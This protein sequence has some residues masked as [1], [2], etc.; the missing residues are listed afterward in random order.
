MTVPMK[1]PEPAASPAMQRILAALQRKPALSIADLAVEAF[2]GVSTLACGG[3]IGA[4]RKRRLIHVSGWRKVHGRFATPLYSLG[5]HDDVPRPRIDES[6]RAAPGMQIIVQ[7]LERY[8]RLDY[9]EIA[10]Y[11]GL[12]PHTVKNSGFLAALIAQ[13]RIH[14]GD[15]RRSAHGP[16]SPLYRLGAGEAAPKP[17]ALS[18]A[19][20][21]RRQRA[22]SKIAAQG[23]GLSSQIARLAAA[24]ENGAPHN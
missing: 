15:W 2:V 9:R 17:A 22:R 8:G 11:S 24:L 5:Q 10:R 6:N 4:L 23:A 21:C 19:Q 18:G 12:S 14:I 7:T 13:G 1:T 16:L 20:K 3:Y